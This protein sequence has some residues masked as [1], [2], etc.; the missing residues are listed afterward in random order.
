MENLQA[1]EIQLAPGVLDTEITMGA[2]YDD[3]AGAIEESQEKGIWKAFLDIQYNQLLTD[4][5][6]CTL[7]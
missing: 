3:T 4:R 7:V 2:Q 5:F 1:N 6:A